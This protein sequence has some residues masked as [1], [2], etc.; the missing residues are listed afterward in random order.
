M[1]YCDFM[2][3]CDRHVAVLIDKA[4]EALDYARDNYFKYNNEAQERAVRAGATGD[5]RGLAVSA[6]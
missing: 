6:P 3:H 5:R 1:S 2:L 4:L